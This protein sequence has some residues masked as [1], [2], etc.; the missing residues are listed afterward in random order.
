MAVK[1]ILDVEAG[2]T[3]L[4]IGAGATVKEYHKKLSKFIE[5]DH[6]VTIGINNMTHLFVP[7]YHL[8][9]NR[10][11]WGVFGDCVK[12]KSKLLFGS[13]IKTDAIR[14]HHKGSF[15]RIDYIDRRNVKI[16]FDGEKIYGFFRTAGN[17][18]IMLA[19]L[20]GAKE[21]YIVG[22][23]GFTLHGRK[24]LKKAKKSHHCYG[25]GYTDDADWEECVRKDELVDKS[26]HLIS[27]YGIKFKIITPT[28]F[29]DFFKSVFC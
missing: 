9:T 23:D 7:D 25:K 13:S 12:K 4:I 3:F 27:E 14:K 18:A 16:R 28:K 24:E 1:D 21:I 11:R 17:L 2:K 5:A 22:M 26:L 6:P 15:V 20:M 19:H 29:K 8:W 10:Q